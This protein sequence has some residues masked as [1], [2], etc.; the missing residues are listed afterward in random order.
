MRNRSLLLALIV[1]VGLGAAAVVVAYLRTSPGNAPQAIY[2]P[3]PEGVG[4]DAPAGSAATAKRVALAARAALASGPGD[5]PRQ[6]DALDA[7]AD[8]VS[9]CV[10]GYDSGRPEDFA[11]AR[12]R[13]GLNPPDPALNSPE[14]LRAQ[15]GTVGA[16]RP[17]AAA[18]VRVIWHGHDYLPATSGFPLP[19]NQMSTLVD[20]GRP[21]GSA[22]VID[23]RQSAGMAEVIVPAT[24]RPFDR[25]DGGA[26]GELHLLLL[27]R[28]APPGWVLYGY[29]AVAPASVSGVVLPPL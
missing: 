6:A 17:I 12:Q 29:R 21:R 24:V 5:A 27:R 23:P 28:A 8:V 18:D 26:E 22:D 7:F 4:G 19:R 1:I 13:Q 2:V 15:A 3:P 11:D 16:G 14:V 20:V 9:A 10:R 25:P